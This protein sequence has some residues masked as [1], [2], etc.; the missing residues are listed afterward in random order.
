MR[1]NHQGDD[2]LMPHQQFAPLSELITQVGQSWSGQVTCF[3][4]N[5]WSCTAILIL[6][7]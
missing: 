3:K 4:T 5:S 7:G 6:K 2:Q 1:L